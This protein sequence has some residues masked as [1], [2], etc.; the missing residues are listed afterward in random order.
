MSSKVNSKVSSKIGGFLPEILCRYGIL[1]FIM[2][3]LRKFWNQYLYV[4][5]TTLDLIM[6]LLQ[7]WI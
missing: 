6:H 7:R 5:I 3:Q 2:A 4:F 1:Y